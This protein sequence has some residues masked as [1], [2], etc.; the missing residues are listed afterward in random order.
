MVFV[1]VCLSGKIPD[2]IGEIMEHL[3]RLY[4]VGQFATMLVIFAVADMI[5]LIAMMVDLVAGLYKAHLRGDAHKS[6]ALK[7]T[8]FK[9]C[10]YEG[11]ML[12]ASGVDVLIY[13]SKVF[14]WFGWDMI[15][16][17]PLVTIAMGIFWC[18]VEFLSVREKADDK[19][20]ST[21]SRAEKLAKQ[22][23]SREELVDILAEAMRKSSKEQQ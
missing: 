5:V 3:F 16:G 17:L 18:T 13:L 7:R 11:T 19:M 15:N 23:F 20:H 1:G 9:F 12:I 6:E 10:L 21:I 22:V 14:L 8:G 2:K 4:E